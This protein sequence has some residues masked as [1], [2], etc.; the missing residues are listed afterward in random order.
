M[1][2][3]QVLDAAFRNRHRYL[4]EDPVRFG[5]LAAALMLEFLPILPFA[6][7]V[8]I[9]A[10]VQLSAVAMVSRFMTVGWSYQWGKRLHPTLLAAGMCLD[11]SNLCACTLVGAMLLIRHFNGP[12]AL[13]PL[14]LLTVAV[15]LLPDARICRWL[16]AS[17]P[18]AQSDHLRT[19]YF[20]RDPVKLGAM[21]S[22]AVVCWLDPGTLHYVLLSLVFL[23]F[24]SLLVFFDKY[25]SE[26]EVTRPRGLESLV[27]EREGRRLLVCLT[28][29]LLVP[30]R[31]YAGDPTAWLISATIAGLI[32]VP[33][34][35]RFALSLL[36]S[37]WTWLFRSRP[38]PSTLIGLARS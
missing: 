34:L 38:H 26:I 17:E 35:L 28:P 4:W 21:L 12:E 31:H 15:C 2:R 10:I 1:G 5:C 14:G 7:T 29:L 27:M 30:I 3:R 19:G 25:A 37:A 22:C 24:N 33:D 23:Q 9:L 13:L 20:W 32:V 36:I 18:G 6:G 16:L 11:W 8:F